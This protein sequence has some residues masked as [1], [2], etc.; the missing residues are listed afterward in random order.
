MNTANQFISNYQGGI[1]KGPIDCAKDEIA[2][3]TDGPVT[4]FVAI[5]R[6]MEMAKS[7]GWSTETLSNALNSVL[8]NIKQNGTIKSTEY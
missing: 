3:T 6:A 7:G 8:M 5:C 4:E 1:F 2:H